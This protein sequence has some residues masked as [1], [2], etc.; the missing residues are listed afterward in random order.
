MSTNRRT[1]VISLNQLTLGMFVVKLDIPWIDSPF[2]KHTRLIKN[3]TDIGKLRE[4]GVK[5]V[6]ID[7]EKGLPP[8]DEPIA[9]E[10]SGDGSGDGSGYGV[11]NTV[12][13][14]ASSHPNH[15]DQFDKELGRAFKIRAQIHNTV[16]RLHTELE[17]G[18]PVDT[19][20]LAPLVDEA[21]DS[22]ERN[23][24]ALL[25][26]VHLS[27]KSQKLVGHSF[28]TFCLSLNVA[29]TLGV[30]AQERA[31]LGVATLLHDSG[32]LQLP[33]HLMGKRTPYSETEKNLVRGHLNNGLKLLAESRLSKL[34]TRIIAEHH[35]LLDGSGYPNGLNG[36]AIHRA[37]QILAV[38]DY[39]DESVH[40]LQDKPGMLPTNVL[41]ILYRR[42]QQNKYD[43]EVVAALINILGVYPVTS[44]V[45]LD[46]GEKAVVEQ[47]FAEAHLEPVIRIV[48][49]E[50]GKL[51]RAPVVVDMREAK[52]RKIQRMLEPG[53][54]KDDPER[55]LFAAF[56]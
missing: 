42:A 51:L 33:L 16:S 11:N 37:S 52:T 20:D 56:E 49:G 47:V 5:K 18:H 39:Y 32:W 41:R 31:D 53:N 46:T 26:L 44:A 43:A 50:D 10:A 24:Q 4:A 36:S 22:L 27:R 12:E 25:N 15:Q 54:P 35:E 7:L 48:Y 8:T 28:S 40:Q 55:K 13:I 29:V 2:M 45:E 3:T 14:E 19:K 21:V 23:N 30:P 38:V 34:V 1:Q 9:P 17:H 6:V